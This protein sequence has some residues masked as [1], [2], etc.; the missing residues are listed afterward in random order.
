MERESTT[1]SKLAWLEMAVSDGIERVAKK[2]SIYDNV[3]V[4]TPELNKTIYGNKRR[5]ITEDSITKILDR[6]SEEELTKTS[7][8]GKTLIA[9]AFEFVWGK[10][11]P[12]KISEHKEEIIKKA[13][14]GNKLN[15]LEN[16]LLTVSNLDT[17][18]F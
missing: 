14:K 10:K 4:N 5:L 2:C 8:D 1:S 13:V 3:T 16:I 6:I 12:E 9:S 18:Y 17:D 11:T 15:N 7:P